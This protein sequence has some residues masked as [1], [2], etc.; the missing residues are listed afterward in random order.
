MDTIKIKRKVL[1]EL[2]TEIGPD[3]KSQLANLSNQGGAQSVNILPVESLSKRERANV[4]A[5]DEQSIKRV[6]L[7]NS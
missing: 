5:E 2:N 4:L 3:H 7:F 6:H 1:R